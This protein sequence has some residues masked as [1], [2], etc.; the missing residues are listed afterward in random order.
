MNAG[1]IAAARRELPSNARAY[2]VPG[3]IEVFGKHTDYAGGRSLL[4]AVERGFALVA[5]PR[6]DARVTMQDVGRKESAEF[7]MS[8]DLVPPSGEWA[9]YPMVVARRLVRNFGALHGADIAFG[10]D[11][12]IASGLSSSAALV[13][14]V[15]LALA[16]VNDLSSR[17][18]FTQAIRGP[19][20]LAE[21]LGCVENGY[22]FGGLAGD[23][24]VGTFGGSEDHTA[25]LNARP[26]ALVQYSFSPVRFE[27]A[28]PL[29]AGHV[30]AIAY[31]GVI[32]EKTGGALQHYN[33]LSRSATAVLEAWRRATG[34][35]DPTLAAA[36]AAVPDAPVQIRPLLGEVILRDRFEQFLEESTEVIPKAA[37]ALAAGDLGQFGKLADYSMDLATRLLGNQVAET[38]YLAREARRL[39]AVA[40]S[41]FGAGFG[42][43]VWALAPAA[44]AERLSRAWSDAYRRAFPASAARAS[45]FVT[46]AGPP[47]QRLPET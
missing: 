21:Y 44:D 26:D 43:S 31:S 47:A 15:F 12:P 9:N 8:G 11:L 7:V 35:N 20:Q 40:A 1:L 16:D 10:S 41:A 32:A 19:E 25:I 39:G 45:F 28:I 14:A 4:C 23:V 22:P 17:P 27:G 46:R 29:P 24:G 30:F 42:G 36:L 13:T 2:W 37:A 34:R 38:V 3:R 5:A 18:A 33:A 6:R